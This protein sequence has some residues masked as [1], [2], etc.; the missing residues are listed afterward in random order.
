MESGMQT[1]H[2]Q[3]EISQRPLIPMRLHERR[4]EIARQTL[5]GEL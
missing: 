2:N 4:G 3:E 5:E 1:M